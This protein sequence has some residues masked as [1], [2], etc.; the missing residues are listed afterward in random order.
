MPSTDSSPTPTNSAHTPR[1]LMQA[2]AEIWTTAAFLRD[3][4]QDDT[5]SAALRWAAEMF[6]GALQEDADALLTV[7]EAAAVSGASVG[8][9]RRALASGALVNF[10]ERYRPRVRRGELLG[11][12][13]PRGRQGP[14]V[15]L[16][17]A[18]AS[19]G[20]AII[21]H[22]DGTGSHRDVTPSGTA[23]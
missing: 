3:E 9:I 20:Q 17:A 18:D 11:W 2:V 1:P 16:D 23:P 10:G 8:A 22:T 21:E 12:S 7:S 19:G 13:P 14:Q 5:R 4:M 6:Q 15:P